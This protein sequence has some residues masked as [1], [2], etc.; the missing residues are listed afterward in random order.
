ML[1]KYKIEYAIP[2]QSH[3]QSHVHLTNDPVAC[4]EFL[5]ELLE[6]GFHIKA[7]LHEGVALPKVEFDGM[8]R[9]AA[10]MLA[11]KHICRSLGIDTVEAHRRFGSVA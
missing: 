6:R 3:E 11:T 4:E 9:T 1:A 8:I 2:F 5:T 10:G 7:L